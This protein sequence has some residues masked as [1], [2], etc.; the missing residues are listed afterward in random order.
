MPASL[1]AS[2]VTVIFFTPTVI[3]ADA[4]ASFDGSMSISTNFSPVAKSYVQVLPD[5]EAL[6]VRGTLPALSQFDVPVSLPASI[7]VGATLVSDDEPVT[8][9]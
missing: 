1:T 8:S 6:T 7:P 3:G 5:H 4:V 9:T 2:G